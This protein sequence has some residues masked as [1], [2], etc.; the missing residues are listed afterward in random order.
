MKYKPGSKEM[1]EGLLIC[2][3]VVAAGCAAMRE[4]EAM[5]REDLLIAAGFV[6]KIA[7]TPE[8]KAQLQ[9][10]RPLEL[11][12][13]VNNETFTYVFPD[14]AHCNCVYVGNQTQY[15]AYRKLAIQQNIAEQNL[16]A[17]QWRYNYAPYWGYPYGP[18]PPSFAVPPH[19]EREEH[20]HH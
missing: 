10:L 15:A 11:H 19:N 18:W 17:E 12:R 5:N 14:P 9:S 7:R 2:L 8:E 6:P 16:Q 13:F 20:E 3:V 4:R 1:M